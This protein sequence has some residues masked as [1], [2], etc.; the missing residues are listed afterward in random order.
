MSDSDDTPKCAIAGTYGVDEKCG[1][2]RAPI[3]AT[4]CE[5]YLQGDREKI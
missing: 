2:V 4:V 3:K 1:M 5:R